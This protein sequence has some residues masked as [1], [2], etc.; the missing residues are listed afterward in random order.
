MGMT[1]PHP[2]SSWPVMSHEAAVERLCG[3]GMPF[4]LRDIVVDGRA[5]RTWKHAPDTLVD[6]V[7]RVAVRH[8]DRDFLVYNDERVTYAAWRNAASILAQIL[9]ERGV[10]KGDRVALAMRNLPEWPVVFFAAAACGAIVVPLNGWWT[11]KELQFAL[12]DS[13]A[14]TLICDHEQYEK[15]SLTL[16]DLPD[17]RDVIVT[18]GPGGLAHTAL[19]ALIGTP[20]HYAGFARTDFPAIAIAPDDE[21]FLFYTSGTTGTPKGAI[22]THRN[23]LVG[24]LA[25]DFFI[26]RMTLRESG[27]FQEPEPDARLIAVPMFHVT[28]CCSLLM[29]TLRTGGKMVFMHKWDAGRAF[30]LIEAEH[31]TTTGGVPTIPWQLIEHPERKNHDLSSLRSISTGGGPAAPELV[32]LLRDELSVIPVTGYGLTETSAAIAGFAGEDYWKNLESCGLALPMVSLKVMSLDGS[33]EMPAGE[34][35]EIWAYGPQIVKGYWNNDEAT[36]RTFTEG[37]AHTGD[38]GKIDTDGY[39]YIVDR[40]K[41]VVIRGGEN[42]YSSEVENVLYEHP[43]VTDAALIGMPH[44]TLGEV[45]V[46]AVHL[47][48][49]MQST[50]EELKAWVGQHLANFKIPVR[51]RI[52]DEPLQRNASGKILKRELRN[53]FASE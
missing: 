4:E 33:T 23:M 10:T 37:W 39:C 46:A 9:I 27:T 49:G 18:R 20:R 7:E 45:P 14:S 15:L 48:P 5:M 40:A 30:E 8:A 16:G 21:L 50:E 36:A 41:D 38:I 44:R 42:I 35:G 52:C 34:I 53:L 51:I 3:P 47:Y 28:A 17:L 26:A 25:F 11:S 31:I 32:R 19:E 1:T 13:G 2:Q 22:G 12:S 24:F 29:A 6:L 43:A